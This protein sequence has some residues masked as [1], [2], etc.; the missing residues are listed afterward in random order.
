LAK[1]GCRI[2]NVYSEQ[3]VSLG[4]PGGWEL[5]VGKK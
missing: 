4:H 1:K 5:G 2:R 3:N